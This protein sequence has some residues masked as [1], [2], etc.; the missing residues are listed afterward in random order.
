MI[1]IK[2]EIKDAPPGNL[3]R[4]T[5][6]NIDSPHYPVGKNVRIVSRPIEGILSQLVGVVSDHV[7]KEWIFTD[8]LER[9][10]DNGSGNLSVVFTHPHRDKLTEAEK[11]SVSDRVPILKPHKRV[12]SETEVAAVFKDL[13]QLLRGTNRFVYLVCPGFNRI[14]LMQEISRFGFRTAD[15]KEFYQTGVAIIDIGIQAISVRLEQIDK[16]IER[17]RG[18]EKIEDLMRLQQE[19]EELV[20]DLVAEPK[21]LFTTDK[22]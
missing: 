2:T 18:V 11:F 12:D 1:G 19:R 4:F 16:E 6:R 14:A 21:K 8:L 17:V 9:R 22:D 15:Q 13:N 10:Q 7:E 20:N 3:W 5:S